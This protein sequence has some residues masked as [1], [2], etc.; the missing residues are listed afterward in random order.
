MMLRRSALALMLM[1]NATLSWA[2]ASLHVPEHLQ[3]LSINGQDTRGNLLNRARSYALPPGDVVLELRYSDVVEADVGDSHSNFKSPPVGIRFRAQDQQSY[4]V[5]A[6]RPASE[7]AARAFV[8]A[9]RATVVEIGTRQA[10]EQQFIADAELKNAA[11]TALARS[12]GNAAAAPAAATP[13][14]TATV[15]TAALPAASTSAAAPAAEGGLVEQNLWYWWQQADETARRR[16]L[17]K[18]GR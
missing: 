8:K 18:I 3:L 17:Q 13:A 15:A 12:A 1:T 16:F 5:E 14:A 6:E 9:P 4:A 11:L 10:P 7:R 2:S